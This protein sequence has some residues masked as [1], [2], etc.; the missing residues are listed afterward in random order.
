M[1]TTC[2]ELTAFGVAHLDDLL[3]QRRTVQTNEGEGPTQHTMRV[4]NAI[5]QGIASD[6][7]DD[8]NVQAI[9][10]MLAVAVER[11]HALEVSGIT[12]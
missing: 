3:A 9:C 2:D 7:A 10:L 8:Q 1:C 11:L 4:A 12:T 6:A 5:R